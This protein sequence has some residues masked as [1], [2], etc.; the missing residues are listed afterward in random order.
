MVLYLKLKQRLMTESAAIAAMGTFAGFNGV[1]SP[2]RERT[3]EGITKSLYVVMV[4]AGRRPDAV[5][6]QLSTQCPHTEWSL[7]DVDADGFETACAPD[8]EPEWLR[9]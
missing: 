2:R 9:A 7:V 5:R 3:V 8:G 4:P 1:I 6:K